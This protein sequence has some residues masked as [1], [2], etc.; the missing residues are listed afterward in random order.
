[1]YEL[2]L[3]IRQ[4]TLFSSSTSELFFIIDRWQRRKLQIL[5]RSLSHSISSQRKKNVT[6]SCALFGG[7]VRPSLGNLI[8]GFRLALCVS[9]RV[10]S[11]LTDVYCIDWQWFLILVCKH[12]HGK[13][14]HFRCN[15][16]VTTDCGLTADIDNH[17]CFSS[18]SSKT[19][20][21]L[22]KMRFFRFT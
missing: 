13:R 20:I 18:S 19:K 8:Y 14:T 1:M 17:S 7:E 15:S 6:F 5:V 3:V 22:K 11:R 2:W 10:I 4:F 9:K 12:K 21:A 16:C